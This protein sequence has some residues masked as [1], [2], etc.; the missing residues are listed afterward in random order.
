MSPLAACR[1][2]L[3]DLTV[4]CNKNVFATGENF[5]LKNSVVDN[6]GT[7]CSGL[8]L[9]DERGGMHVNNFTIQDNQFLYGEI[10]VINGVG[11]SGPAS[12]RKIT[13][14]LIEHVTDWAGI[15]LTGKTGSGWTTQPI[16][17]V[18]ITGNTLQDN[19]YQI[20]ARGSDYANPAG[21]WTGFLANNTFD[22]A[23]LTLTA[24]GDA[25]PAAYGRLDYVNDLPDDLKEAYFRMIGT[26]IQ[27]GIDRAANGDTV[28]VSAGTYPEAVVVNKVL[29]L[30]GAGSESDSASST[31]ITGAGSGVGLSLSAGTDATHRVVIKDMQVT[32]FGTGVV[33]GSYNTLDNVASV[34][35]VT[36]GANLNPLQ[37][38]LITD[39][40]FNNNG[41]WSEACLHCQRQTRY[42]HELRVQWQ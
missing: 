26:T 27:E 16:G 8:Y 10:T 25:R 13:G 9:S 11:Q 40:K 18:T 36:Y 1:F 41:T 32:G 28:Q 12:G 21:Y 24:E 31:V 22:K 20:I 39:S 38:L 7:G 34:S 4:S 2:E 15:S 33:A 23:V 35:N 14:N 6:L 17:D 19:A 42:H 3:A 37:D 5:T 30:E 29:T